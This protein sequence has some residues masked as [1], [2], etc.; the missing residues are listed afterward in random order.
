M[1]A[2]GADLGVELGIEPVGLLHSGLEVIQD[3]PPRHSAKM[4]KGT[5]DAAEEVVGGLAVD[6]LA[7]G[8]A[9]VGQHD[10]EDMGFAAFAVGCE[11]WGAGA[12][13]DLGLVTGLAFKAAE[14]ELVSGSRR[15]TKRRTL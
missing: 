6:G 5:L 10:A 1:L 7:V 9:G 13:V 8:L 12:E 4:A 14:G 2:E 3:Q 15:R 11:D